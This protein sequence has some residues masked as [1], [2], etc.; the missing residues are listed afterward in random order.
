MTHQEPA[1]EPFLHTVAGICQCPMSQLEDCRVDV[2]EKE[3][4]GYTVGSDNVVKHWTARVF[5]SRK[6]A[7]TS[8]PAW[9]R[10][11][12]ACRMHPPAP[13]PTSMACLSELVATTENANVTSKVRSKSS[14]GHLQ[15][16][17]VRFRQKSLKSMRPRWKLFDNGVRRIVRFRTL[18]SYA[19]FVR[20]LEAYADS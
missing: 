1:C 13:C 4:A 2:T 17:F 15:A 10:P 5:R 8:D 16:P 6:F 20:S 19:L 18:L 3:L 7:C 12:C 11:A 14:T 9:P